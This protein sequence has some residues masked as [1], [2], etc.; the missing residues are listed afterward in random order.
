M[1]YE[2]FFPYLKGFHFTLA[3]H[4][5]QRDN[6]RWK[7][8]D[9]EWTGHMES[10]V[11]RGMCS[12]VEADSIIREMVNG[13][14]V[15]P[16]IMVSPV[17]RFHRC[18]E[19]LLLLMSSEK[20]PVIVVRAAKTTVIVYSCVDT[21]GSGFGSTLLL[22]GKIH[23]RIGTWSSTEDSNSSNWR[24]F[25]NLVCEV[26]QAG[27]KSW[28]VEAV[29]HKGNSSSEKLFELIVRLRKVNTPSNS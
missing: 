15:I 14:K 2:I 11:E 9:L 27:V 26:D 13:K 12:R 19:A 18:L 24:E 3:R 25:E 7:M 23:Y 16:D 20:P 8:F 10:K 1:V 5:P 6:E 28:I 17:P 4:L 21:S 22:K 29:L